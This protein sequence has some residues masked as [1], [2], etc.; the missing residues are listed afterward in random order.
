MDAAVNTFFMS[1]NPE[2]RSQKQRVGFHVRI[3][4]SQK[5]K[6]YDHMR[7]VAQAHHRRVCNRNLSLACA[8]SRGLEVRHV[9]KSHFKDFT[10]SAHPPENR[11]IKVRVDV[12]G[13]KT[14]A[15]FDDIFSKLVEAAQPIPG[16]QRAKGGKTPD[17]PKDILL[18]ILGPSK[19]NRQSIKKIINSTMAEY[20]EKE[21][22]KI[23]K[24]LRVHQSYEELEEKFVP[25]KEFS[26]DAT[27]QLKET[28]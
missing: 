9:S 7:N 22:L 4:C 16:F 25:G 14:Q 24:E 26:F 10:I 13:E 27:I 3:P 2:I 19:V 23:T 11:D 17:I 18:N 6:F 28:K 1:L 15:A 21:G 12:S 5:T 8:A 20:T